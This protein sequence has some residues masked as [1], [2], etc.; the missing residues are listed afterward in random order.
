MGAAVLDLYALCN[1][2]TP[3]DIGR[4]DVSERQIILDVAANDF[5]AAAA[6]FAKTK[7]LWE[8][9]KPSVLS[10]QGK[11]VADKYEASLATQAAGLQAKDIPA[12]IAEVNNG[13]EIVD[14]LEDLY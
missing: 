2:P 11:E 13:L 3:T 7:V 10:H 1:P 12:L 8:S 4:L 6:S 14:E 9:V 5:N